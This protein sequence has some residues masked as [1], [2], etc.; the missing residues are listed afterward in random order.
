M[1]DSPP[2]SFRIGETLSAALRAVRRRRGLKVGDVAQRMGMARRSY[3]YFEA[4]GT[5]DLARV[6][7]FAQST[8]SDP[9]ALLVSAPLGSPDLAARCAD[10][11]MLTVIMGEVRAF[12]AHLGD[13]LQRL[14]ETTVARVF[15]AAFQELERLA[16]RPD[17]DHEA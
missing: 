12:D 8:A 15:A 1:P 5:F 14:D 16:R 17:G 11:R 7:K 2:P 6:W 9:Y 13:D 10:N 3:E 4:K